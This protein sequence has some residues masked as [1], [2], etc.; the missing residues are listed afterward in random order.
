MDFGFWCIVAASVLVA[1]AITSR[2]SNPTV[3]RS[4]TEENAT[5]P[6]IWIMTQG[7]DHGTE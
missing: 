5:Y 1:L 3:R 2:W 4:K 6:H 7:D